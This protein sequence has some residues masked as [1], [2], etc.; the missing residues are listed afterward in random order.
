[1]A[2]YAVVFRGER[3]RKHRWAIQLVGLQPYIYFQISECILAASKKNK[4]KEK[5]KKNISIV[6]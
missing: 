5:E 6:V 3:L 4:E 1:M 2:Q